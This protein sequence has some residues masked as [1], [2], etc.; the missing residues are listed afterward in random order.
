MW[1]LLTEGGRSG[2]TFGKWVAMFWRTLLCGGVTS[3]LLGLVMQF[4]SFSKEMPDA[5]GL[6]VYY[7]ENA[8]LGLII[9]VLSQAGFF[10]YLVLNSFAQSFFRSKTRW[11]LFL[12][13]LVILTFGYLIFARAFFFDR[14]WYWYLVLPV[15]LM[16]G[17]WWVAKR[18]VKETNEGAFAPTLF[19]MF[20]VTTLEAVPALRMDDPFWTV[21][22]IVPLFVCNAYQILVLHKLVAPEPKK[23]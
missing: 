16:A 9:S 17:A 22:M 7:V 20:T 13:F 2:L 8:G 4:F 21:L 6:I 1:H 18:K 15:V 10:A 5:F 19:L 23:G 14:P 3:L 11:D 12:W